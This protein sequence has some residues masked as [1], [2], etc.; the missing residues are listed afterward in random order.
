[1]QFPE[2]WLREFCNPP[3][4]TQQLA[5]TLTMAGL[6]VEEMHPVAPPFSQVVVGEIKSAE[7]HPNADRLRVCQVDVGAAQ[8]LQIVCGAPNARVGIKV[9]CAL[10][11]AAL[12]PGED[13]K[14]FLIKLGQL[15][16]VESQGML[17]SAKELKLS[18]DS[19]GLLEL[20]ESATV[21]QD[22]RA[23]LNLDDHLFTLKLTPNLAH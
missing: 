16:G 12:P 20:H 1:M 11:G 9:P 3:I 7:Q 17:C 5:D 14:P 15:R 10:V 18:D 21:G 19:A 8:A 22:I 4:N 23:H 6:E 2:S 13:G